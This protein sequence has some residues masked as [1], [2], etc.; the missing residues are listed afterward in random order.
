LKNQLRR[1]ANILRPNPDAAYF[2]GVS[3][4]LL[5]WIIQSKPNDPVKTAVDEPD[6]VSMEIPAG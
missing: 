3:G 1:L 4:S 5:S 6:A 2:G